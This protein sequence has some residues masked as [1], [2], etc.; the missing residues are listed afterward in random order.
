MKNHCVAADQVPTTSE[1]GKQRGRLFT[2]LFTVL[3]RDRKQHVRDG[4][5]PLQ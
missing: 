3:A 4:E 5:D 2:V 1:Y